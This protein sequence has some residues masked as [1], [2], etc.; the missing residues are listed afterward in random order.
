MGEPP[1]ARPC[2]V[3][4]GVAMTTSTT[5]ASSLAGALRAHG[6]VGRLVEPGDRDYELARAGWNGAIDRHPAAVAYASDADDVASAIQAARAA[7]YAFTIRAG[8]HSASGR[9]VRDGALCI[10]LRVLNGVDVDPESRLVRAGGG[11]LLGELD[12]A[13]QEHGLAVPG[14]QISHTGVGGLTLGG[15]LGWLMRHHGLTIDSME[16]AEVVLADGTVV[17]ASAEKHPDLFWAL[18]GG[19]GDFGAVTRFDFRAHRVGPTVLGGML[20]YP[21]DRARAALR[22]ARALMEGA[23]EPLTVFAVLLTAPPEPPFPPQL[24]GRPVVSIGIAWSGD[25]EEGERVLAPLRAGCPPALDLVEP[26]PYVALQSM[27]DGTAPHGWRFYDRLHYLDGVGDGLIDTLIAAFE[28]VPTPQSHIITGWMGG[29]IDRVPPGATAFGHR[30]VS[31]ETW[32]IGCSPEGPLG[33]VRDWVRR[34]YDEVAPYS[35]GGTYVNAL[36]DGRPVEDAYSGEVLARLVE[37]KRRY[38]PDGAFSANGIG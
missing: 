22:A 5:S 13:T 14:G 6:F 9:S 12:A 28:R 29:A 20:A 23:P 2:T 10:D 32:L 24:Q 27:L 30:G 8:G 15:G 33:P 31:A 38:D 16:G 37:V 25:L 19:G 21:W 7:G 18:R 26:M 35:T 4:D 34:T 36:D 11:A 3:R 17:E 1:D